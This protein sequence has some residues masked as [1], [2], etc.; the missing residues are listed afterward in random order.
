ML[1]IV[2]WKI[3]RADGLV[4]ASSTH[5][6]EDVPDGIQVLIFFHEHPYRTL[7]YGEDTYEVEGRTLT[8]V[9]MQ[10]DDYYA[11]VARAH[12]DGVWP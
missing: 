2:G 7:A 11:L 12:A 1:P 4:Y 6:I 9:W 3:Y 5:D 10:E 8:G